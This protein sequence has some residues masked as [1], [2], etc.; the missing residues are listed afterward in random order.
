MGYGGRTAE[1]RPEDKLSRSPARGQGEGNG[2]E[3]MR[4][5]AKKKDEGNRISSRSSEGIGRRGVW[6]A[7]R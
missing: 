7:R 4:I 6:G 5:P 3:K 2:K 1:K